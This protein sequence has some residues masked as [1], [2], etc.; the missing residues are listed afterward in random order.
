MT[1]S[2]KIIPEEITLFHID[3][4]ESSIKD[5]SEKKPSEFNINVAHT[6][7][8]NLKDQRV[9]IGLLIDLST[10]NNPNGGKANFRIDF[11]FHVYNLNNFYELKQDNQP[12]F[13]WLLIATLLGLSFST[14]RGIIFERLSN[15]NLKHII[16]PV[17]DPK[18]MLPLQK[19]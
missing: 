5:I 8:H 4:L 16:L 10:K 9:K 15:T 14:A 7:M 6:I 2:V 13:S 18:N 17:V 1:K 19:K 3:I 12:V 11:H